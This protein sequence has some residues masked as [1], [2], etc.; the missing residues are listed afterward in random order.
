MLVFSITWLMLAVTVTLFAMKTR[1]RATELE[2]VDSEARESGHGVALL[3]SIYGLV[4]LAGFFYVT[5]FFIS[6]P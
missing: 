4:L 5:K 1:S 6:S 2:R 3:A